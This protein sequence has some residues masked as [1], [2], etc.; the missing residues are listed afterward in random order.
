MSRVS[1]GD[2]DA[3]CPIGMK[4]RP[5]VLVRVGLVLTEF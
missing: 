5:T 1:A 2:Y 4:P 3:L